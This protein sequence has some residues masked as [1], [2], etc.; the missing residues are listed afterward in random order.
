[1]QAIHT[2]YLGPTNFKGGRIKATCSAGSVTISYPH[3]LNFE[4]AHAAAAMALVR[5]LGW[6]RLDWICG[7]GADGNYTFV[8]TESS[9]VYNSTFKGE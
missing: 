6:L 1:M 7:G 8:S 9:E 5:K 3:D 2:K 4:Q